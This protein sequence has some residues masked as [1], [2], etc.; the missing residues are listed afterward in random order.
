ME[1]QEGRQKIKAAEKGKGSRKGQ[2]KGTR[3][4][5]C[6]WKSKL[7][8]VKG[9]DKGKIKVGVSVRAMGKGLDDEKGRAKIVI[10]HKTLSQGRTRS[11]CR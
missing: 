11:H 7:G 1:A 2:G 10:P 3:R 6:Q 8:K 5:Q 4:G 9:K